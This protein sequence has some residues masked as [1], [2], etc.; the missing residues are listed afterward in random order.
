MGRSIFNPVVGVLIVIDERNL[1]GGSGLNN[2]CSQQQ[3][4]QQQEEQQEQETAAD[5]LR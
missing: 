2:E 1:E 4:Q 3:G 5:Q